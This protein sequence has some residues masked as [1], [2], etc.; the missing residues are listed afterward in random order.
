MAAAMPAVAQ[1]YEQLARALG[2]REFLVGERFTWADLAYLPF[3]H[4]RRLLE[5]EPPANVAAWAERL[6]ARPSAR[7]TVPAR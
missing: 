7:A 3:L 4:F 6:A 5:V 2:E 1:H